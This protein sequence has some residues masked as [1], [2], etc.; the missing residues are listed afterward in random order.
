MKIFKNKLVLGLGFIIVL[1]LITF[2][3][4]KIKEYIVLRD[5]F[6]FTKENIVSIWR[7]KKGEDIHDYDYKLKSNEI[8]FLSDM[9]V[10]SKLKKVDINDSPSNTLGSLTVLLDGEIK[11]EGGGIAVEFKRGITLIPIDKENVYVFLDI[12]KP[13]NDGSL[14]SVGVMQKSYIIYSERLVEFI[15][16][17]T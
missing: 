13:R 11:E 3:Y 16:K 6:V 7:V 8:D 2:S 12:N 15:N 5:V 10:N 9:L 17:N 1:L 4:S 14:N